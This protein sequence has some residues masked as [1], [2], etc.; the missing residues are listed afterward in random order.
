M[1]LALYYF[2]NQRPEEALNLLMKLKVD[3]WKELS[4]GFWKQ[5]LWDAN[6]DAEGALVCVLAHEYAGCDFVDFEEML[7]VARKRF[8]DV[9]KVLDTR[10]I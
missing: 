10:M 2:E 6:G 8:S 9:I 1:N 4:Y 5:E 3:D 7:N